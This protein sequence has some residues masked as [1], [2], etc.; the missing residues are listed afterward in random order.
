MVVSYFCIVDGI[1]SL[2]EKGVYASTI[3]NKRRYWPKS[4]P[5]GLI[6][7]GVSDKE[8]GYVDMLEAATE[9][10]RPFRIFLFK[11]PD[12]VIKI[13]VLWITTADTGGRGN[14]KSN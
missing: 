7:R 6:G 11:E 9:D 8:V 13:M 3:I 12:Y 2:A 10:G 14:T 5:G 4:V 1:V